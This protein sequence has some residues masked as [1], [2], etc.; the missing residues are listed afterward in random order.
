MSKRIK[1]SG[2]MTDLLRQALGEGEP[3]R[4]VARATGLT[5]VSLLK[6]LRG[7]TS[8]RLDLADKLAAHFGIVSTWKDKS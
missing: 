3:L 7:D 2:T 1:T 6:F 8:L 4:A 5:H